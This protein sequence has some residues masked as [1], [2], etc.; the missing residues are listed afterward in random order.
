MNIICLLMF[1]LLSCVLLCLLFKCC[2]VDVCR[3][4]VYNVVCLGVVSFTYDACCAYVYV[5][6]F[7]CY[8]TLD[9]TI[10]C[11]GRLTLGPQRPRLALLLW[12]SLSSWR[13]VV[14][15]IINA[16]TIIVLCYHLFSIIIDIIII[17]MFDPLSRV[18]LSLLRC[19]RPSC[20]EEA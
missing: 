4:Y 16:S 20:S 12:L 2:F 10:P 8:G 14:T 6:A 1:L 3:M 13:L 19:G 5:A 9:R 7:F 18:S 15:I 17:I 11:R